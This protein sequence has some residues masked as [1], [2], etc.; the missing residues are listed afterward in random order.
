[1][2]ND[3][4][5]QFEQLKA[6]L[7]AEMPVSEVAATIANAPPPPPPTNGSSG[8]GLN[9][10]TIMGTTAAIIV[11]SAALYF[12]LSSNPEE[13]TTAQQPQQQTE[14]VIPVSEQELAEQ[15]PEHAATATDAEHETGNNNPVMEQEARPKP[16]NATLEQDERPS[17]TQETGE[18]PEAE[19]D[20]K[21]VRDPATTAYTN[22]MFKRPPSSL[23][24]D[25][26]GLL[27]FTVSNTTTEREVWH[28]HAYL[29]HTQRDVQLKPIMQN[30][31]L[32]AIEITAATGGVTKLWGS[33]EDQA[34]RQFD[35]SNALEGVLRSALTATA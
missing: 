31:A 8:L 3:L 30:G 19:P 6:S 11:A 33:T 18:A 14:T 35:V 17:D 9:G 24:A 12:G 34:T 10:T 13:T 32:A 1:M 23:A 29:H 20:R 27:E 2:E 22:P 7:K 26:G 21:V 15:A 4:K 28:M 5:P 25:N 16:A